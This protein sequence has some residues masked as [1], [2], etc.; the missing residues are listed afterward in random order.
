MQTHAPSPST[1]STPSSSASLCEPF[2]ANGMRDHVTHLGSPEAR[3]FCCHLASHLG[4]HLGSHFEKLLALDEARKAPS[5]TSAGVGF[6]WAEPPHSRDSESREYL[7]SPSFLA[8]ELPFQLGP[9]PGLENKIYLG[10][11]IRSH[12]THSSVSNDIAVAK[13]VENWYSLEL[14]VGTTSQNVNDDHSNSMDITG[15]IFVPIQGQHTV[16]SIGSTIFQND[17]NVGM[18]MA[19]LAPWDLATGTLNGSIAMYDSVPGNGFQAIA[20]DPL[21]GFNSGAVNVGASIPLL[22]GPVRMQGAPTICAYCPATFTRAS[23]YPRHYRLKHLGIRYHCYQSGC[24]NNRGKG[25]CRAEKLK[26]HLWK[27]HGLA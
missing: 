27:V 11:H 4:S 2:T 8:N 1:P 7:L 22:P 10:G 20:E 25:Y 6:Q 19:D 16:P 3:P 26:T 12:E 13:S 24:V 15:N 23:D 17:S 21:L 5:L 18:A 14:P 9:L